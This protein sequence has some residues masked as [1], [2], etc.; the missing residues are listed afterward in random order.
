MLDVRW[1]TDCEDERPFEVPP[2]E[3]GHDADCL[4]LMCA[5]CGAAVVVGIALPTS[6]PGAPAV[7][8]VAAA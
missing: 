4:D 3:D 5:H 1:C 6:R 8:E 2:C 7:R